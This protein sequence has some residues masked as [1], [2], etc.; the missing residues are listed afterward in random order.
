[1]I[2][3]RTKNLP[4][5]DTKPRRI[6]VYADS[7]GGQSLTLSVS[8]IPDG[9]NNEDQHRYVVEQLCRK[10]GWAGQLI[11]GGTREG[12]VFV[13]VPENKEA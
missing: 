2:S 1:M 8:A 7:A 13:F 3:I 4:F 9:L 5:T 6:K 11:A 10:T 12:Y